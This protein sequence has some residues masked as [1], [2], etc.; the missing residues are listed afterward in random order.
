MVRAW[1]LLRGIPRRNI[2]HAF[3]RALRQFGELPKI[4]YRLLQRVYPHLSVVGFFD[5]GIEQGFGGRGLQLVTVKL[6]PP[7]SQPAYRSRSV[8][9]R[10]CW[11]LRPA[12]ASFRAVKR[13]LGLYHSL[14]QEIGRRLP[15]DQLTLLEGLNPLG[16]ADH[17]GHWQERDAAHLLKL[18]ERDARRNK[19]VVRVV[20]PKQPLNA[21][22]HVG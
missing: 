9:L 20:E 22:Q 19:R 7:K 13:R 15:F 8:R 16:D 4:V 12:R 11:R 2:A 14:G 3:I 17:A 6:R 5:A 1:Q 18:R 10:L 21:R